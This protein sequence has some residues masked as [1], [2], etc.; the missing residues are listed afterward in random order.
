MFHSSALIRI[1]N[2]WLTHS[3]EQSVNCGNN[4][5]FI[6]PRRKLISFKYKSFFKSSA[7]EESAG[8]R[9]AGDRRTPQAAGFGSLSPAIRVRGFPC[10]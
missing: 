1:A 7:F 2:A 8:M 3:A 5:D 9:F 10:A 4:V 6:K